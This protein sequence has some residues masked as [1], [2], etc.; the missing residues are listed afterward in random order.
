MSE[1]T[2][3]TLFATMPKESTLLYVIGPLRIITMRNDLSYIASL[4]TRYIS[5]DNEKSPTNAKKNLLETRR[6]EDLYKKT[7]MDDE[8]RY[9]LRTGF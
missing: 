1:L 3:F 7:N 9:G 2:P 8:D 5:S 4:V 6:P